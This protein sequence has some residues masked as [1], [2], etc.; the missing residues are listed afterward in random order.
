MRP[1]SPSP[2]GGGESNTSAARECDATGIL[3]TTLSIRHSSNIPL[4]AKLL[5]SSLRYD[6]ILPLPYEQKD[7]VHVQRG[8]VGIS[9]YCHKLHTVPLLCPEL[10][11]QT[12]DTNNMYPNLDVED[13][14]F[15]DLVTMALDLRKPQGE[16]AL[17]H[18]NLSLVMDTKATT[19]PPKRKL[20]VAYLVLQHE[21]WIQFQIL[22]RPF[23]RPR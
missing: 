13:V 19:T 20:G 21:W 7:Y 22:Q 23:Y 10:E 4:P 5:R 8:L 16:Q 15:E 12:F 6:M 18:V 9:E 3:L 17:F 1:C 11:G 2:R 14:K